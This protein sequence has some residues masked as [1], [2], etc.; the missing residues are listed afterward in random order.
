VD[1]LG[2]LQRFGVGLGEREP[3][4]VAFQ[5]AHAAASLGE[6]QRIAA[7]AAANVEDVGGV[8]REAAGAVGGDLFAAGLFEGIAGEVEL[9]GVAKP[10]PRALAEDGLLHCGAGE[11]GRILSAQ[12]AQGWQH[13]AFMGG[14]GGKFSQNGLTCR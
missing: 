6:R 5:G 1:A 9:L 11:F 7:D 12:A 2:K 10:G 13:I 4:R 14:I 3:Q 8:G